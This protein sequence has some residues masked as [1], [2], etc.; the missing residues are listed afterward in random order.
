MSQT[1][2]TRNSAQTGVGTSAAGNVPITTPGNVVDLDGNVEHFVVGNSV[3]N[4]VVDGLTAENV[5]SNLSNIANRLQEARV[6]GN[7]EGLL[8]ILGDAMV[9]HRSLMDNVPVDN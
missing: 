6:A 8:P 1:R 7:V 2:C 9:V 5:A 3:G 4:V